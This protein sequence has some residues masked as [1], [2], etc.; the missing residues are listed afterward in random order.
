[1]AVVRILLL[2]AALVLGAATADAPAHDGSCGG[3]PAEGS[4][5]DPGDQD[6]DGVRTDGNGPQ[7]NCPNVRNADQRN[8]DSGYTAASPQAQDDPAATMVAGDASGDA[9]DDDDDADG[10]ADFSDPDGDGK[11]DT[12]L[13]NCRLVRNPHQYGTQGQYGGQT[14]D[15]TPLCPP[16]DGDK[17]GV[18]DDVDNCRFVPNPGQEDFD[19]DGLGDPCEGDDDGDNVPDDIDNCPRLPNETQQDDDHDGVG[20]VCD[21]DELFPPLAAISVA[22]PDRVAPEL[23]IAV[24]RRPRLF[25]LQGGLPTSVRCSEA[26]SLT[27]ELRIAARD[28]RRLRLKRVLARSDAFVAAAGRTYLFW[29]ASGRVTRALRRS[30]RPVRLQIAVRG[31]D[32]A[33]NDRSVSRRVL[34]MPAR[35]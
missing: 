31:T 18:A 15:G 14:A 28:A 25:D 8:T 2:A 5:P 19:Y 9:C 26:C 20:R 29:K 17:D 30:S 22:P 6:C 33:G 27:G 10:V 13:D 16:S 7:D 24:S 34:L 3:R 1:M 11:A 4:I 32:G 12:V 35:G 21:R 23:R